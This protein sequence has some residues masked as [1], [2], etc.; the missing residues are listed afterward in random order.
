MSGDLAAPF[1]CPLSKCDEIIS[2]SMLLSHFIKIHQRDENSVDFKEIQENEKISL[3]VSVTND[4]LE[5]DRNICLGVLAYKTD[6]VM[7]HSNALLS[8]DYEDF[9]EHLPIL[10][11][12]CRGNYIKMFDSEADYIDPDADFLA[13][14]LVM[15]ETSSKQK[16]LTTITVHNEEL[17]KSLSKL[18]SV[19]HSSS[20]QD[21]RSL[22]Q[23]ETDFLIVNSGFLNEIA[24]NGS[25][26]VEI[27]VIENIL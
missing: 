10:I 6:K 17:T 15:P 5:L 16:L 24:S 7:N 25:I 1:K 13:I 8:Y 9:E 27:S 21:V 20:F 23:Q 26:L 2:S 18:V 19:R 3:M 12:A 22:I 14:W 11:M 4:Y